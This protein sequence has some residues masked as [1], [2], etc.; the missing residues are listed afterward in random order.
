MCKVCT[1]GEHAHKKHVNQTVR[2][3]KFF[4]VMV[5]PTTAS[6]F[7]HTCCARRVPGRTDGTRCPGAD[8]WS[9][10]SLRHVYVHI[11]RQTR[12]QGCERIVGAFSEDQF[13]IVV[14]SGLRYLFRGLSHEMDVFVKH[15][16]HHVSFKVVTTSCKYR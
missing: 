8:G 14:L 5:I 12:E 15:H 11:V 16:V 13:N 4:I 3:G 2:L 10:R 1:A 9:P 7:K 6:N